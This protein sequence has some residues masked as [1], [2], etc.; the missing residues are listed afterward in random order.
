MSDLKVVALYGTP[1]KSMTMTPY[2]HPVRVTPQQFGAD[3]T[4][5]VIA[6]D[7]NQ[8]DD[9]WMFVAQRKVGPHGIACPH[10]AQFLAHLNVD[11]QGGLFIANTHKG[12]RDDAFMY[13][14]EGDSV[15]MFMEAKLWS[16]T[17]MVVEVSRRVSDWLSKEL[18]ELGYAYE[19]KVVRLAMPTDRRDILQNHLAD[20]YPVHLI[21]MASVREL[22]KRCDMKPE[23]VIK[24]FRANIIVE[25]DEP[26]MERRYTHFR[27]G[28]MS[29]KVMDNT[30]RCAMVNLENGVIDEQRE[31]LTSLVRLH[32]ENGFPMPVTFGLHLVA[33]HNGN[34]T[35]G[36]TGEGHLTSL[37]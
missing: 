14:E 35:V 4:H 34:L 15:H 6:K 10:L 27:I 24:R 19:F 36:D 11:N 26:F 3:R 5:M 16:E 28:D 31:P 23:A 32:K 37:L 30:A 29:F 18:N 22:A 25:M 7:P 1:V 2:D 17:L 33:E 13:D 12:A 20:R 21:S 8:A 9:Q